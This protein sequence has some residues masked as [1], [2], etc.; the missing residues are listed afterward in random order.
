[1]STI[2]HK[3]NIVEPHY[4]D[5]GHLGDGKGSGKIIVAGDAHANTEA[6]LKFF[7]IAKKEDAQAIIQLGDL[8][9]GYRIEDD[10]CVLLALIEEIAA[11]ANIPFFF[12]DGNHDNHDL[13]DSLD[14]DQWGV[15][16]ISNHVY[17][18]GRGSLCSIAGF[19][20]LALGGAH[21]V[22]RGIEGRMFW[23]HEKPTAAEFTRTIERGQHIVEDLIFL[24]HDAPANPVVEGGHHWLRSTWGDYAADQS[25]DNQKALSL[26]VREVRPTVAF[27]GHLHRPYRSNV[28]GTPVI[29][30]NQESD[31]NSIFVL[32]SAA[33]Q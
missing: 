24:S 22:D 6:I 33:L 5:G 14:R 28:D 18:L 26:V 1:M 12:I 23:E 4:V 10:K 21:S 16:R 27:H 7:S 3:S 9:V 13:L 19:N 25:I 29:G 17:H 8:G 2:D 15:A 20:F 30:L 31:P 11:M 32:D